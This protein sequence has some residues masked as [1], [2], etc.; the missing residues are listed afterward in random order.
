[1]SLSRRAYKDSKGNIH[2]LII[3]RAMNVDDGEYVIEARNK[4]GKEVAKCTVTVRQ[5]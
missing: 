1:M 4:N 2:K 5:T 3:H